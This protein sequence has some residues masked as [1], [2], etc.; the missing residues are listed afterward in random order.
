M[1]DFLMRF[2]LSLNGASQPKRLGHPCPVM[3]Q[4]V[5]EFSGGHQIALFDAPVSF[6]PGMRRAPISTIGRRLGE[7]QPQILR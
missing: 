1:H 7:K 2:P 5:V 4:E 3:G 6:F